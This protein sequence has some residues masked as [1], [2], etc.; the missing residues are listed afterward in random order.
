MFRDIHTTQPERVSLPSALVLIAAIHL[1]LFTSLLQAQPIANLDKEE[2]VYKDLF[3]Q[4]RN[5]RPHRQ[6]NFL[7]L[8]SMGQELFI[9]NQYAESNAYFESAYLSR[10]DHI[11]RELQEKTDYYRYDHS[12]EMVIYFKI[13]NYLNLGLIDDALVECRRMDELFLTLRRNHS[14]VENDPLI[15][16]AMGLTYEIGQDYDNALISY[17]RAKGLYERLYKDS[18]KE[19]PAQLLN[20]ITNL[21]RKSTWRNYEIQNFGELVFIWHNGQQPI[22]NNENTTFRIRSHEGEFL[23]SDAGAIPFEDCIGNWL[24]PFYKIERPR[25]YSAK[26]IGDEGPV[27]CELLE[28]ET[29]YFVKTLQDRLHAEGLHEWKRGRDWST[30][31]SSISYLRVPLHQGTNRFQFVVRGFGGM[32]KTH[33]FTCEGN[34]KINIHV[35]TSLDSYAGH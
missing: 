32:I 4:E 30:L 8:A 5:F 31:P 22:K 27:D 25:F 7:W 9:K 2:E 21:S 10:I 20:D 1:N 33:E 35:F 23:A 28:D 34:G 14:V 19:I 24:M 3:S 11:M 15:H 17:L 16:L 29:W 12:L 13:L 6:N 18:F 26:L